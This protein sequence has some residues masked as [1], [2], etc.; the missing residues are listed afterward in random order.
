LAVVIA[1]DDGALARV[2]V[3]AKRVAPEARG[4]WLQDLAAELDPSP[5]V[6]R[7]RAFRER[8]RD[9]LSPSLGA[10]YTRAWRRREKS[11]RILLRIEV[12]EAALA[13]MLVER[14]WLDPLLADDRK[15][16]TAAAERVLATF[17]DGEV[18]PHGH[19]IA[20]K[21]RVRLCLTA[22]RRTTNGAAR[23]SKPVA[24]RTRTKNTA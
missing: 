6:Q 1:L 8:Q 20:D 4:R 16:L 9:G 17:C 14:R 22:L 3:A 21:L 11:G 15:S 7:L 10:R 19:E 18:S 24:K 5:A 23:V 2:I 12:D 13:A